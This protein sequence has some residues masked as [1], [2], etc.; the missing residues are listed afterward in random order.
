MARGYVLAH[1]QKPG[2]AYHLTAA[3]HPGARIPWSWQDLPP[4]AP[5]PEI[6]RWIKNRNLYD[7]IRAAH[8]PQGVRSA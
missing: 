4:L 3:R 1:G 2:R 5:T 8:R 7:R 6:A